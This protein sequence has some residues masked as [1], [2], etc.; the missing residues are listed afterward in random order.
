MPK[1]CEDPSKGNAVQIRRILYAKREYF[2]L[3]KKEI[4]IS[5]DRNSP[6]GCSFFAEKIKRRINHD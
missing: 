1:N 5:F 3:L 2:L 4:T 6:Q